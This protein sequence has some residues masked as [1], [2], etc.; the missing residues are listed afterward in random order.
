MSDLEQQI[1]ELWEHRD[2]ITAVMP[3]AE[4]AIRGPTK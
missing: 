4:A 2:D 3:E 1:T